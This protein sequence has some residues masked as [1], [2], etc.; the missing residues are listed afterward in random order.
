M[1]CLI[2]KTKSGYKYIEI[3]IID[4]FKPH[5]KIWINDKLIQKNNGKEF[6]E[7]TGVDREL[8]KTD[9]GNYVL[10][11]SKGINTF[12]IGRYCGFKG[13]SEYIIKKG[14]IKT[15]LPFNV[16]KS[17]K[18]NL[19][20][21]TYA[22]ISTPDREIIVDEFANGELYGDDEVYHKRYFINNKG[23]IETEN[24]FIHAK[25]EINKFFFNVLKR[26]FQKRKIK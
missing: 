24:I 21:S 8:V 20:V 15:E 4:F 23:K 3:G 13:S 17:E 19:G 16:Y 1:K 10:R 5:Y 22:I 9:K 18:G 2:K 25:N 14:N 26:N 6:V 7:L 12:I 11:P